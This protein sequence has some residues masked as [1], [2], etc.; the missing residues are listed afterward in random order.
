M[1]AIGVPLDHFEQRRRIEGERFGTLNLDESF[2][3]EKY[4]LC[5]IQSAS[6]LANQGLLSK[7]ALFHYIESAMKFRE[8]ERPA[9]APAVS[10]V[11]AGG[12]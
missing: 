4:A 11:Q 10:S 7:A 9:P 1:V 6:E 12:Q 8:G 5:V 2:T 3:P